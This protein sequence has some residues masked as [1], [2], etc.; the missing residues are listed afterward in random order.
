MAAPC[1]CSPYLQLLDVRELVKGLRVAG[2]KAERRSGRHLK[3]H[4]ESETYMLL[5]ANIS[6][7]IHSTFC[8]KISKYVSGSKWA[9]QPLMRKGSVLLNLW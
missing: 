3:R 1:P 6:F 9:S 5:D 8:V 4:E 7:L 2:Q